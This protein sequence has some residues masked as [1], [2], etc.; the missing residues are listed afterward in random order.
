[1][2]YSLPIMVYS[3]Y[4]HIPFCK[5]RCSY[6]D[7]NTYA[8]LEHLIP[9]YAE[10]LCSEIRFLSESCDERLPVHTV[11][12]GGGTPSLLAIDQVE[13][14]YRTLD[15]C[16]KIQPYIEATLEANPGT[17]SLDHLQ[18]LHKIGINRLSLE[19][20]LQSPPDHFSGCLFF[21][22]SA[23]AEVF[24]QFLFFLKGVLVEMENIP[25]LVRR[26]LKN[27]RQELAGRDRILPSQ[28]AMSR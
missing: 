11:Y 5:Q 13:Q 7:F 3:I 19:S 28:P 21:D 17:L 18:N 9:D 26:L 24:P 6:C 12:F 1:M 22:L 27:G 23:E 2:L 20:N 10:A 4:I 8:G 16:F 25:D 15:S 14:I